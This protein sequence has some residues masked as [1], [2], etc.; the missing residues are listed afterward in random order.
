M[1]RA[2]GSTDLIIIK[3]RVGWKQKEKE[4]EREQKEEG[5]RKKISEARKERKRR[6]GNLVEN[7]SFWTSSLFFSFFSSHFSLIFSRFSLYSL[8][9]F[10]LL[11]TPSRPAFNYV[12]DEEE[13]NFIYHPRDEPVS[14]L[15]HTHTHSLFSYSLFLFSHIDS[16][17][18]TFMPYRDQNDG[19]ENGERMEN[20]RERE[21]GSPFFV[22]LSLMK[23]T[24]TIIWPRVKRYNFS[25]KNNMEAQKRKSFL[26]CNIP[27]WWTWDGNEETKERERE[28]VERILISSRSYNKRE[29]VVKQNYHHHH[30]FFHLLTR[31]SLSHFLTLKNYCMTSSRMYTHIFTT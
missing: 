15:S 17:I 30:P 25:S 21:N 7:R 6:K 5:R 13:V 8:V 26:D 27:W 2:E 16:V 28:R 23:E 20:E 24:R 18:I 9:F 22:L 11:F 4:R 1:W 19:Q 10:I 31:H 14:S 12:Q 29:E 3:K